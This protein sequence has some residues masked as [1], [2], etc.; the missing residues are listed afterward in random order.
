MVELASVVEIQTLFVDDRID[1]AL[2]KPDG[3]RHIE[4]GEWHDIA[5]QHNC[6]NDEQPIV[7]RRN[8]A[9][10]FDKN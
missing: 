8:A 6:A 2:G 9:V 3:Q 4:T 5:E 1:I 10:N 7:R